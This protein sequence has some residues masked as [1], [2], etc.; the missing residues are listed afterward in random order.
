MLPKALPEARKVRRGRRYEKAARADASDKPLCKHY[1][2]IPCTE[3]RH[4]VTKHHQEETRP[5]DCFEIA[6]IV[7]WSG[8]DANENQQE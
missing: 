4:H 1:L 8:D 5:D 2:P 3:I 7:G 6:G